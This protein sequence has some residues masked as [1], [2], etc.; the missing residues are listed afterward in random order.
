M[1]V[2]DILP[3]GFPKGFL[4]NYFVEA[5][6]GGRPP[7]FIISNHALFMHDTGQALIVKVHPSRLP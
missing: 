3:H 6:K 7:I 5:T 1:I 2:I 4:L